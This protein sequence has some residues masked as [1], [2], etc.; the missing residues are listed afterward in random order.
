MPPKK[1]PPLPPAP[2]VV[3]RTDEE[4]DEA[5]RIHQL[6]RRSEMTDEEKYFYDR[7]L[8][9]RRQRRWQKSASGGQSKQHK[10]A[11]KL[12]DAVS[13]CYKILMILL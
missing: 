11:K 10:E 8:H 4:L 5:I 12:A 7:D 9:C 13:I 2:V 1:K 3:W 6:K